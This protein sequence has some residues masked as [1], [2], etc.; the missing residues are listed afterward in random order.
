MNR[1]TLAALLLVLLAGCGSASDT[2]ELNAPPSSKTNQLDP[3]L[4]SGTYISSEIISSHCMDGHEYQVPKM[5][6]FFNCQGNP[7]IRN[8]CSDS[9]GCLAVESPDQILETIGTNCVIADAGDTIQCDG[10]T[11]HKK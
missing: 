3:S 8:G 7:C 5:T 1:I 2:S 6:L 9:I 11:L 4:L 10:V